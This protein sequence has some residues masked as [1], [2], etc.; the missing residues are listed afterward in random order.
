MFDY[1]IG[2][3]DEEEEG[4]EEKE[5]DVSVT[6]F[7]R[8]RKRKPPTVKTMRPPPRGMSASV[9]RVAAAY[10]KKARGIGRDVYKLFPRNSYLYK[11]FQE[12]E[13]PARSFSVT[14]SQGLNHTIPNTVVVEHIAQTGP[15]ER[16]KIEGI[17]RQIDFKNGDVNHFLEHLANAIADQYSGALR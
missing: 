8:P 3:E 7:K 17:L 11:F 12:K 16:R 15:G 10:L 2:M 9:E 1:E 6:N 4:G 5:A 13:I 14:D